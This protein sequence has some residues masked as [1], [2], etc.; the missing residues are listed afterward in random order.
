M[1]DV[2]ILNDANSSPPDP[3]AEAA[4]AEGERRCLVAGQARPRAQLI[5]FVVGPDNALYVDLAEKLPGRGLWVSA[6]RASIAAAVARKLFAKA[7]RAQVKVPADLVEQVA[8]GLRRRLADQIGL[9]R[10]AGQAVAGYE[11]VRDWLKRGA[12]GLILRASDGSAGTLGDLPLGGPD[13][14][15]AVMM[16]LNADELGAPFA[17]PA[18][19]NVAIAKGAMALRIARDAARVIGMQAASH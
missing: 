18:A 4:L 8:A 13:G 3:S 16:P 9:A 14:A 17:R 5:R 1:L 11:K 19:V 15:V 6:D 12:A 2:A 10:R 7:A